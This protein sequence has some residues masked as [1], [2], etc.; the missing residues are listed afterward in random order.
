[1]KGKLALIISKYI[2]ILK[3]PHCGTNK[4]ISYHII[5]YHISYLTLQPTSTG[6]EKAQCPPSKVATLMTLRGWL[7]KL[8][9]QIVHKCVCIYK[10]GHG[11]AEESPESVPFSQHRVRK[12]TE[13][14]PYCH[15]WLERDGEECVCVCVCVRICVY[16]YIYILVLWK[17]TR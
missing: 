14:R 2:Y 15:D 9:V 12:C 5:S 10:N 13:T 3:F 7:V 6:H 1:M 17:I 8:F 16:I 11:Q 4:G